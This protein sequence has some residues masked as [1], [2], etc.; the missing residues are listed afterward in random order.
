[1]KKYS[2]RLSYQEAKETYEELLKD[3]IKLRFRAD[4]PVGFNVSGGLDSSTLLSFVNQHEKGE[5]INAFTFYTNDDRYDE[6][7]WV[8]KMI[9]LTENPLTPVLLT[10]EETSELS[11]KIA[12]HQDEPYGGIPT[13]AY[14][15]IFKTAREQGTIVLL[16]GQ[17]MDEQWAGYDYYFRKENQNI[18]QG[19]KSSPF[20]TKV[21]SQEF[22]DKAEKP[23]YPK[24]FKEDLLNKQYRD[25]FYTKIPRALRFNDRV[26]MAFSTELRE[27]FLDYRLVEFAFSQPQEYKIQDGVQKKLLRDLVSKYLGDEI[28]Y[29]PKRPLQTPQREWLG[30]ELKDLVSRGIEKIATSEFAHWFDSNNLRQEW[31]KYLDGEQDSSFHIWQWLSLS[32]L[33]D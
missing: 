21:F 19:V 14:S 27:P 2:K 8:E 15:K 9:A 33:I 25:L 4:V 3:S 11:K 12:W 29:A 6:L 24:P 13:I 18:I 30:E 20:K 16:D 17:G 31:Q 10:S 28:T 7:P 23:D 22:L 5:H 32:M 26:S 1:M